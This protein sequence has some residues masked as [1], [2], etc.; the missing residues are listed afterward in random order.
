MFARSPLPLLERV[1]RPPLCSSP[2]VLK[3]FQIPC[4]VSTEYCEA[5]HV[6]TL[7]EEFFTCANLQPDRKRGIYSEGSGG[8]T[9]LA[10][11]RH[12]QHE[13]PRAPVPLR[14]HSQ[15]SVHPTPQRKGERNCLKLVKGTGKKKVT[16]PQTWP[17][18]NSC[19]RACVS[20]NST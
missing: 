11:S 5:M 16:F 8:F 7:P 20:P 17:M 9:G 18:P 15:V 4:S 13:R 3:N 12:T 1:H 10:H 2:F 19:L 6:Q 14:S